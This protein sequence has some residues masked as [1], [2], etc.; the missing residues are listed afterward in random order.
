MLITNETPKTYLPRSTDEFSRLEIELLEALD[1]HRS[2]EGVYRYLEFKILALIGQN[3]DP[4]ERRI[5]EATLVMLL[6]ELK[7][8]AARVSQILEA[9]RKHD[10]EKEKIVKM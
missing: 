1:R 7:D 8:P 3:L 9:R 2:L 5:M 4:A 6:M 10:E